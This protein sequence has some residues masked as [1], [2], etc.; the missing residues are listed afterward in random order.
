MV[1]GVL[2]VLAV[3]LVVAGHKQELVL[4]PLLHVRVLV[5]LVHHLDHATHNLVAH[6]PGHVQPG[7]HAVVEHLV[8]YV[9]N[10]AQAVH[11]LAH[12]QI[13]TAAEMIQANHQNH[14]H[15]QNQEVQLEMFVEQLVVQMFVQL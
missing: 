11:N 5:V 2:T 13:Q 6:L 8:M 3:F 9:T 1:V 4:I 10:Q 7:R 15:A 14:N 12:A